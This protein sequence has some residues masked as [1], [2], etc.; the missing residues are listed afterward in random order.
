MP[1]IGRYQIELAWNDVNYIII[2]RVED[3]NELATTTSLTSSTTPTTSTIIDIQVRKRCNVSF[4]NSVCID[5]LCKKTGQFIVYYDVGYDIF[6]L[7]ENGKI[8][9]QK[10]NHQF[11]I[12][13][14]CAGN[15]WYIL[16]GYDAVY[17]CVYNSTTHKIIGAIAGRDF[18]IYTFNNKILNWSHTNK[19]SCMYQVDLKNST[20]DVDV[21][22]PFD[23]LR[24]PQPTICNEDYLVFSNFCSE[25][26]QK[27][28]KESIIEIDKE[29]GS[30]QMIELFDVNSYKLVKKYC[31]KSLYIVG[32][33]EDGFIVFNNSKYNMT[34]G[35]IQRTD[36]ELNHLL[37]LPMTSS[38]KEEILLALNNEL[39]C[40]PEELNKLVMSYLF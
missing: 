40:L 4:S 11:D 20:V 22:F 15:G 5:I 7:D 31:F 13:H 6:K 30:Y 25:E 26:E 19:V 14:V 18:Y 32:R 8:I 37:T 39:K 35:L 17:N 9:L 38:L 27:S 3:D 16:V 33:V 21:N 23:L 1:I 34:T 29:A 10:F 28:N 12:D 2:S 24:K 36:K